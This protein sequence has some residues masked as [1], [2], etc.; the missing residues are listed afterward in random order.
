MEDDKP[1]Y[2]SVLSVS[3]LVGNRI[4]INT[5]NFDHRTLVHRVTSSSTKGQSLQLVNIIQ[6]RRTQLGNSIKPQLVIVLANF[7]TQ[8]CNFIWQLFLAGNTETVSI[9]GRGC[10]LK[11]IPVWK[12]KKVESFLN[13]CLMEIGKIWHPKMNILEQRQGVFSV[14][15]SNRD[16]NKVFPWAE[17][18]RRCR[19][20]LIEN[21]YPASTAPQR[22]K[23]PSNLFAN[24]TSLTLSG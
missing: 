19:S 24:S 14:T 3:P 7:L 23:L 10:F 11:T 13:E 4:D 15:L 5:W 17:L 22:I 2:R 21:R 8:E 6:K 1:E 20:K 18:D 12:S 9:K 16:P